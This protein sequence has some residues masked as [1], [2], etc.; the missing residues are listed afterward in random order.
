MARARNAVIMPAGLVLMAAVLLLFLLLHAQV[1]FAPTPAM[2]QATS[3]APAPAAAP[4]DRT[5]MASPAAA[6]E[7]TITY[8]GSSKPVA[9]PKPASQQP[10]SQSVPP[11][12]SARCPSEPG[13][14]LPCRIP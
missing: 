10:V 12:G 4:A 14:G 3:N 8:I 2:H 13:S 9:G 6:S 7:Q 5:T 1:V 11:A